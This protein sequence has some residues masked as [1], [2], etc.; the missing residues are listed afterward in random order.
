[1]QDLKS[2][3]Y[4]GPALSSALHTQQSLESSSFINAELR[5]NTERIAARTSSQ[6]S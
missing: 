2:K 5:L 6:G 3:D 1:M 4:L